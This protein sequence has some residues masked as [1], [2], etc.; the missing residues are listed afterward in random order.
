MIPLNETPSDR[1]ESPVISEQSWNRL[2]RPRTSDNRHFPMDNRYHQPGAPRRDIGST[3][4]PTASN[5]SHSAFRQPGGPSRPRPSQLQQEQQA[6]AE[7]FA[8]RLAVGATINDGPPYLFESRYPSA[9]GQQQGGAGAGGRGGPAPRSRGPPPPEP[10]GTGR[11]AAYGA[12]APPMRAPGRGPPE[13]YHHQQY[14]A[15]PPPR[16]YQQQQPPPPRH[17]QS[18]GSAIPPYHEGSQGYSPHQQQQQYGYRDYHG[19]PSQQYAPQQQYGYNY[20][21]H[22]GGYEDYAYDEYGYEYGY[23]QSEG[24]GYDYQQNQQQQPPPH[25]QQQY[26]PVRTPRQNLPPPQA[27]GPKRYSYNDEDPYYHASSYVGRNGPTNNSIYRTTA[28]P[29][30][31]SNGTHFSNASTANLPTLN[32]TTTTSTST[33]GPPGPP[34][35]A[36]RHA[37]PISPTSPVSATSTH[38]HLSSLSTSTANTYSQTPSALPPLPAGGGGGGGGG[39]GQ[40]PSSPQ[41]RQ[42]PLRV[43]LGPPPSARRGPAHYYPP[44]L[45]GGGVRTIVEEQQ[46]VL[47]GG[48]A[49]AGERERGMGVTVVEA[50]SGRDDAGGGGGWRRT[51]TTT[52]DGD[53]RQEELTQA[54]SSPPPTATTP[55]SASV[56]AAAAAASPP[57]SRPGTSAL[58]KVSALLSASTVSLPATTATTD[59]T[60]SSESA[61]TSSGGA[62]PATYP[63]PRIVSTASSTLLPASMAPV[64][65]TAA[66]VDSV[67]P[68]PAVMMAKGA[69]PTGTAAA[70]APMGPVTATATASAQGIQHHY[71]KSLPYLASSSSSLYPEDE[72]A[73]LP[74]LAAVATAPGWIPGEND[75]T[76]AARTEPVPT[77]TTTSRLQEKK[78]QQQEKEE[79]SALPSRLPVPQ[80]R[81][82][83]QKSNNNLSALPSSRPPPEQQ[84]TKPPPPPPPPQQSDYNKPLPTKVQRPGQ[85][86]TLQPL[87]GSSSGGAAAAGV[88]G[89]GMF[90]PATAAGN[91][92]AAGS[93]G[94]SSPSQPS[95]R[96][97]VSVR[98][99]LVEV[100]SETS[101]ARHGV[102]GTTPASGATPRRSLDEATGG[103]PKPRTVAAAAEVAAADPISP[104]TSTGPAARKKPSALRNA[105]RR[106]AQKK[107]NAQDAAR[108]SGGFS[109]EG[110]GGLRSPTRTTTD[111]NVTEPDTPGTIPATAVAVGRGQDI[112]ISSEEDWSSSEEEDLMGK[113]YAASPR[114]EKGSNTVALLNQRRSKERRRSKAAARNKAV[115]ASAAATATATA[116]AAATERKEMGWSPSGR[117]PAVPQKPRAAV[118]VV[119]PPVHPPEAYVESRA[120]EQRDPISPTSPASPQQPSTLRSPP[121]GFAARPNDRGVAMGAAGR[122]TVPPRIDVAPTAAAGAATVARKPLGEVRSSTTSLTDLIQRATRLASN[123]DRGR[124]ASRLVLPGVA[125]GGSAKPQ[126]GTSKAGVTGRQREVPAEDSADDS[127][128][129]P[130]HRGA[131]RSK[132]FSTMMAA[133]PS[134]RLHGAFD[135]LPGPTKQDSY[136]PARYLGGEDYGDGGKTWGAAGDVRR[137]TQDTTWPSPR[138]I[139]AVQ[140]PPPGYRRHDPHPSSSRMKEFAVDDEKGDIRRGDR[141]RNQPSKN[142]KDPRRYCCGLPLWVFSLVLVGVIVLVAL[143]VILPIVLVVIPNQ[144]KAA[145]A[146]AATQSSSSSTQSCTNPL[147]CANG[148]TNIGSSWN[149]TSGSAGTTGSCVCLCANGWSGAQCTTPP[150]A[151]ADCFTTSLSNGMN[152]TIGTSVPVVIQAAVPVTGI[153]LK[154]DRLVQVFSQVGLS[155][156]G[157]N[158]LL[159]FNNV[160][161]SGS[162]SSSTAATTTAAALSA[163]ATA[164]STGTAT[165]NGIIYFTVTAAPPTTT[166]MPVSTPTPSTGSSPFANNPPV[167]L[168]FARAATLY[169]L[170][171]TTSLNT[172]VGA[173]LALQGWFDGTAAPS[174]ASSPGTVDL[175]SGWRA[176]VGDLALWDPYGK[177]VGKP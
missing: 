123:L 128:T 35:L 64:P 86:E 139:G 55:T 169:V 115:L 13:P 133:F 59:T 168:L 158:A 89:P 124:T 100:G 73:D 106:E 33:G 36:I 71:R 122:R 130:P 4:S 127:T 48:G 151:A 156:Q 159:Q 41:T 12:R 68:K 11:D 98:P 157:Q 144:Q 80:I 29:S 167:L 75:V 132:R 102:G 105:W 14:Q 17:W 116:I 69:G 15:P 119:S 58:P 30:S 146:A 87:P 18:Q 79:I 43:P 148:G 131:R 125:A 93:S 32:T 84:Q 44:L 46:G 56:P 77:T 142:K 155:C 113:G 91:G 147:S 143:A 81:K 23:G 3:P 40:S 31:S 49:A 19:S 104:T 50:E 74:S 172:A 101:S 120:I 88:V 149:S 134:P 108:Q 53:R 107:A 1:S 160:G 52:G 110:E 164:D 27:E 45:A 25:Q 39:S 140:S 7:E 138:G 21:A 135:P 24:G 54:A 83:E 121:P 114:A 38:S 78:Q 145:A 118:P 163:R 176:A 152:A 173:Q 70:A 16:Q 154:T 63:N 129:Q 171:N 175:G 95:L 66:P 137:D 174:T 99:R 42:I 26:Q 177:L 111:G 165:S 57:P 6:R 170:Q 72:L 97:G 5:G 67:G 9:P 22:G 34:A 150:T 141:T 153:P 166:L 37:R 90:I 82:D 10:T 2:A 126:Q 96:G 8:A 117:G 28:G 65:P 20:D 85:I 60:S 162:S 51:T 76:T 112:E 47:E 94:A 61:S 92:T 136:R 109:S 161:G 62:N 103:S